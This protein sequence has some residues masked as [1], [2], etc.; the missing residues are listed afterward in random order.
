M[1]STF[2]HATKCI[3]LLFNY[4]LSG[5]GQSGIWHWFTRYTVYDITLSPKLTISNRTQTFV[6][7][8]LWPLSC[9]DARYCGTGFVCFGVLVISYSDKGVWVE[10]GIKMKIWRSV[11]RV[12]YVVLSKRRGEEVGGWWWEV[13]WWRNQNWQKRRE[14]VSI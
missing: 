8:L 11:V 1:S 5:T 3:P 13:T 14:A 6:E 7:G 10:I 12:R 2:A 9:V 4:L